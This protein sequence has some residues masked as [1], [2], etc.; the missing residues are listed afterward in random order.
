M[1][2]QLAKDFN[3]KIFEWDKDSEKEERDDIQKSEVET[4]ADYL[5]GNLRENQF[6]LWRLYSFSHLPV[7]VLSSVYEEL[8]TDSKDI[9]YTPEMIVSTLVDECMPLKNPQSDFKMIDVSCGSGI[10]LVKTYKRIVQWWRYE[11]WK[12]T[13]ELKKPSLSVLKEL[14]LKSI[15]GID[16]QQDAIRLSVFSL[17]LAILDEVDL[18][19]KTWG[20]LSFPDLSSNV[21]TEDFFKTPEDFKGDYLSVH[22][23]GFSVAPLF[24]QSA[25]FR[26]HNR[27]E[28]IKN[29]FLAGAGTHPGA[30]LPGVICSAKVLDSLIPTPDHL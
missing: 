23:A 26:F 2:D 27:A 5:D 3:G 18:D 6:L 21:I 9:V 25:W 24:R 11:Q 20:K 30:G 1:L 29:L 10:F 7:E 17:A 19:P 4:L 28:G 13:G 12:Q 22:G 8:L 14:L 16:I 15:Y